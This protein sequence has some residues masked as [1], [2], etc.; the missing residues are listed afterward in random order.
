MGNYWFD[1]TFDQDICQDAVVTSPAG[2]VTANDGD[3]ATVPPLEQHDEFVTPLATRP[4][5]SSSRACY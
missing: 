4:A 2:V 3:S 5:R 1:S